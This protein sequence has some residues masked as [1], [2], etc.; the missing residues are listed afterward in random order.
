VTVV[1]DEE[2]DALGPTLRYTVRA[3]VHTDDGRTLIKEASDRPGGPTQPMAPSA[4]REKFTGL[5]TPLLGPGGADAVRQTVENL[6]ALDDV[7][8]LAS[9]LL[10]QPTA[11]AYRR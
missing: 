10:H 9:M 11:A 5:V 2:I 1:G 6:E 8:A 7:S 4:I 3:E